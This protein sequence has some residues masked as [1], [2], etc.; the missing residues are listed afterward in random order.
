M[1]FRT[2]IEI[3]QSK[4]KIKHGDKIMLIGSCFAESVGEKLE[5]LLFYPDINPFG[6]IYNPGSVAGS[7]N[8]LVENKK[9]VKENLL[10]HEEQFH[11]F[12]HH[13]R[14]SNSD[15]DK[16]IE[17]INNRI[18]ESSAFLKKSGFLFITFGT[19]WV[20][21]LSN[22]G[23]L[24]SNCHKLADK[25][26]IRRMMGVDEIVKIF[27]PLIEK[28][29][30][31]N[32]DLQIVFTISPVRH[33]KNGAE[34]NMLS[35]SVL[36]VAVHE[37]INEYSNLFYFPSFEIMMDDLRDYRYY[38]DDLLHP[39]S[40]AINYIFEKFSDTFFDKKT[41][42]INKEIIKLEGLITHRPNNPGSENYTEFVKNSISVIKAMEVKFPEVKFEKYLNHFSEF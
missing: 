6:I 20:Y 9:F 17:N 24:V 15:A 8:Y 28:L 27:R 31:I 2:E 35:K 26:F 12:Y 1:K 7:L 22:T 19:A 13:S 42:L 3:K 34:F 30:R 11:S 5:N 38:K 18:D 25:L 16:C 29:M 36:N 39:N 40:L 21:E 14:F 4:V 33:W 41:D 37:L 32:P 10:F 23:E